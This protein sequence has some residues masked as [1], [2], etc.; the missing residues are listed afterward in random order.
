MILTQKGKAERVIVLEETFRASSDKVFKAWTKP[1]SLK[2]WF[3]AGEGVTVL[4]AQVDLQLGGRYQL[5]VQY[6]GYDASSITGEFLLVKQSEELSYTWLTEVL[7]GRT[8]QV[9]VRFED[10]DTGSKITLTH[11]VFLNE[12]EMQLHIEGWKGCI[13]RLHQ[14][15]DS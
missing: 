5:D 9:D 4:E 13:G 3:M 15:L 6:P 8:T 1:E 11:A 14:F 7:Q 2:K 10:L 12:H